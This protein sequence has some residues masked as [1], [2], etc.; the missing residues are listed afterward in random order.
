MA[1][2][3]RNVKASA[4]TFTYSAPKEVSTEALK[5]KNTLGGSSFRSLSKTIDVRH[6]YQKPSKS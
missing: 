2:V 5:R 6:T 1:F 4:R 3:Y